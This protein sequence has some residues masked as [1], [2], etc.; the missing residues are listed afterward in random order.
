MFWL[1]WQLTL[2]LLSVVPAVAIGAVYYGRKVR[3]LQKKFQDAL[4]A[5]SAVAE[6]TISSMRTVRSFSSEN[7]NID[8][9]ATAIDKS[10]NVLN[11]DAD[12]RG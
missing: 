12:A 9:Y 2:V 8:N 4:A 1:S 6:E 10:Y 11:V 7:K 3:K 5:A